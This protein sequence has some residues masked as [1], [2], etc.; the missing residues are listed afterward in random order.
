MK[1]RQRLDYDSTRVRQGLAPTERF[2]LIK[3]QPASAL[4]KT[5]HDCFWGPRKLEIRTNIKSNNYGKS[6]SSPGNRLDI[7]RDGTIHVQDI[8]KARWYDGDAGVSESVL[9]TP[10]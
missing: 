4:P 6:N 3:A 1:Y 9:Q 10:W 7:R 2:A 8:Q 5:N